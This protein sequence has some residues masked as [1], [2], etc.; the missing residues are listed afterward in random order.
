MVHEKVLSN[1][2]A[3]P[4]QLHRP[5]ILKRTFIA[6]KYYLKIEAEICLI[7]YCAMRCVFYYILYCIVA[8]LAVDLFRYFFLK[9]S[10]MLCQTFF[11]N[12]FFW[13]YV[14]TRHTVLA[15]LFLLVVYIYN[16]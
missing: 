16:L 1:F 9:F 15:L 4:S 10:A 8:F 5:N 7:K 3:M 11:P 2:G 12:K 6:Y 13:V 14:G